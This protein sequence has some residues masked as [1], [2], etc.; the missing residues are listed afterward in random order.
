MKYIDMRIASRSEIELQ[1]FIRV[2]QAIATLG[3]RGSGRT[4]QITVDGDG[5][6]KLRFYLLNGKEEEE[7]PFFEDL[8]LD[9]LPEFS[10][11]E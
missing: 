5:S 7:L 6:G 3:V 8:D 10:I 11:G 2:C 1:E 9:N 4:L